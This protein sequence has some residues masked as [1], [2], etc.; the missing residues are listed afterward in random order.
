MQVD[1]SRLGFIV[2]HY[3]SGST[4]LLNLLSL[5]PGIRGVGETHI[6]R[7]SEQKLVEHF[8]SAV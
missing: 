1:S 3:K 5:H 8:S 2:G 7:F 4:W 6:F